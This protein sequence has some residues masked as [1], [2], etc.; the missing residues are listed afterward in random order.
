MSDDE[1]LF[2]W[3]DEKAASNLLRHGVSFETASYVFDDPNRLDEA[4][5]FSQGE[6][7]SIVIGTVATLLLT[8]VYTEPEE[9]LIRIIS[10]RL[11]TPTERKAYDQH[12]FHP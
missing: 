6:Y 5:L 2:D 12:L 8:V 11:A 3:H 4:D 10:A 9:G 7:R 1:L